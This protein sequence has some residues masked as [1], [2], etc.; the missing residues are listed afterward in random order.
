[1]ADIKLFAISD[2][3][4][5][6]LRTQ[7]VAVERALQTLIESN[8]ESLLG[9]RFLKSEYSTGTVHGGRDPKPKN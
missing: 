2:G 4:V 5:G 3:K 7:S 8:L 6:E 9:V 1:L